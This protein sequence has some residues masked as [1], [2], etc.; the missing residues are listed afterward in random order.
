MLN[1][2][3]I[4]KS[5]GMSRR[6]VWAAIQGLI[7]LGWLEVKTKPKWSDG[8]WTLPVPG[9]HGQEEPAHFPRRIKS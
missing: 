5:T 8:V 2:Y 1:K 6:T 9:D 7:E 3:E 4:A